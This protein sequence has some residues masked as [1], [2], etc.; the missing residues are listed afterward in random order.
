MPLELVPAVRRLSRARS[1]TRLASTLLL[2]FRQKLSKNKLFLVVVD[3]ADD[4]A[5]NE[6]VFLVQRFVEQRAAFL[7]PTIFRLQSADSR[8]VCWFLPVCSWNQWSD[9]GKYDFTGGIADLGLSIANCRG[10]PLMVLGI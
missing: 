10:H 7:S 8:G 3:E 4:T 1:S 5:N 9:V 2:K 6:Q